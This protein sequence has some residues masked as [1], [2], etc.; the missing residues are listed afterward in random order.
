MCLGATWRQPKR[1]ITPAK[2]ERL[3]PL[4]LAVCDQFIARFA[5]LQDTMGAKFFP[6]VLADYFL[7]MSDVTFNLP[8]HSTEIHDPH[9]EPWRVTLVD[10][11]EQTATGGRLKAVAVQTPSPQPSPARGEG[12]RESVACATA[13]SAASRG[14]ERLL[15]ALLAQR[16][17]A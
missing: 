15:K 10:I 9:A 5:K 2:L 6:A 1:P 11:G 17:D 8:T 14:S 12:A 4:D 13:A 16:P 3:T 7:H